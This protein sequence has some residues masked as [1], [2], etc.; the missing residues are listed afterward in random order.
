MSEAVRNL[1]SKQRNEK[2]IE[3]F[4]LYFLTKKGSCGS[5][6]I[7]CLMSVL[8]PSDRVKQGKVEELKQGEPRKAGTQ[9]Y[10]KI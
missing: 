7:F 2:Q 9:H 1:K 6:T 10:Y 8:S 3:M 4:S 5:S